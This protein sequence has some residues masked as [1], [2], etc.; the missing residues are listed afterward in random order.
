MGFQKVSA[1][2]GVPRRR[3]RCFWWNLSHA[4]DESFHQVSRGTTLPLIKHT[5]GV[6]SLAEG[7]GSGL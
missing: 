1:P 5:A 3:V 6:G 2:P 7:I 4:R